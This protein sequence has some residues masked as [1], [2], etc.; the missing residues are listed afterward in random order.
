MRL[1]LYPFALIYGLVI[2][3]RNLLYD[4]GIFRSVSFDLPVILV[5]NLSTGGTGKTPHIEYLIRLLKARYNIATLSRGYGRETRGY[6][7]AT[8]HCSVTEIGDE[9]LLYKTRHPEII[10]S[11][12]ENR[13]E[14]IRTLLQA[15]PEIQVIL[16]DDGFQHRRVR[17]GFSILLTPFRK[18]WFRDHL[19]PAGN[20]RE[21]TAGRSRAS[22]AVVTG[23]PDIIKQNE[24]S[25][26]EQA[27]K[28]PEQKPVFFSKLKYAEPVP[29]FSDAPLFRMPEKVVLFAGIADATVLEQKVKD[30]Y[31]DTVAVF[32]G[33]HHVYTEEEISDLAEKFREWDMLSGNAILLTTEKDAM[34]L[35]TAGNA[36]LLHGLPLYYLP[37]NVV[38]HD[39]ENAS[40]DAMI[41]QYVEQNQRNS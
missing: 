23:T 15:H 34:R 9:P 29:V 7:E 19:L 36:S 31:G 30:L 11:V 10:V 2:L 21:Q 8:I 16:M 39:N 40:F 41:L 5:G 37:I 27:M 13:A 35:R 1:L 18:P 4:T 24:K 6:R 14:G 26:F 17:P 12:C 3:V 33:D 22:C 32:F 20:L 28:M 25:S 38:L